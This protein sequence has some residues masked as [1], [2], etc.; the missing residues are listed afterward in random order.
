M[1]SLEHKKVQNAGTGESLGEI[2]ALNVDLFFGV[3]ISNQLKTQG[4]AVTLRKT[5]EAF[6]GQVRAG[7]A[8]LGVIDLNAKPDWDAIAALV[9]VI[10]ERTPILVFGSHLDLEGLRAA[11]ASG[12]RRVVSN[13]EF[14]KNMVELV[15]RYAR[16]LLPIA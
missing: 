16:P 1:S 13:G 15:R 12:V 3:K 5:A 8:V 10:G 14:H 6:A 2:V 9:A 4:Y 11:K 7:D